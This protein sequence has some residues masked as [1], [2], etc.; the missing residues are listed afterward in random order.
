MAFRVAAIARDATRFDESLP[1]Y[2]WQE[3]VDFCRRLAPHGRVVQSPALRGVH[4]GSKNG[5]S[6]GLRLGYSQ[7]AN[8]LYLAGKGSVGRG[9]ALRL[10]ARNLGA[11]LAGSLRRPGLVDRRGRLRGNLLAFRDLVRRRISPGRILEL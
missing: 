9:W 3:D 4:L 11:N 6:S 8:P 1:L 5:R 10:M 7:I 2:A